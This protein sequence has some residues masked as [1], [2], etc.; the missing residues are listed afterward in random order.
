MAHNHSHHEFAA[1]FARCRP[2]TL[3][4][5]HA[6]REAYDAVRLADTAAPCPATCSKPACGRAA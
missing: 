2:F 3:V 1:D 4:P 5:E 6:A